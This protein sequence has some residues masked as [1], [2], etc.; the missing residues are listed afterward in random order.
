MNH[1]FTRSLCAVNAVRRSDSLHGRHHGSAVSGIRYPQP[2]TNSLH[3]ATRSRRNAIAVAQLIRPSS[4]ACLAPSSTWAISLSGG[5]HSTKTDRLMGE[6]LGAADGQSGDNRES[7][8]T[9]SRWLR[10]VGKFCGVQTCAHRW[11]AES[12][13]DYECQVVDGQP[14]SVP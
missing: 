10:N 14:G 4:S 7:D 11:Y 5:S 9:D 6:G 2:P 13:S 1:T 12:R 3:L 8:Q